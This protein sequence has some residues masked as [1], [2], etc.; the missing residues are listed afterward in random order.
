MGEKIKYVLYLA[1][2]M[3]LAWL[4]LPVLYLISDGLCFIFHRCLHYRAKVIR[5]NL[6]TSFPEK[7]ADEIARIEK[8]FYRQLSDNIVES[9]KLL[10]IRTSSIRR[11]VIVEIGRAHV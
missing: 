8:E 5:E 2:F 3:P 4:P 9:I 1:L 10:S 7:S 11:R 6:A